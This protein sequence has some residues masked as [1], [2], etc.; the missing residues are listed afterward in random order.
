MSGRDYQKCRKCKHSKY[1]FEIEPCL[2]CI[3]NK[4]FND[5]LT[6]GDR[7]RTMSNDQLVDLLYTVYMNGY[8]DAYAVG[9]AYTGFRYGKSW[10]KAESEENDE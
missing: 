8:N 7:V 5:Q 10:L 3:D 4:L 1:V 6:N 2:N 9:S